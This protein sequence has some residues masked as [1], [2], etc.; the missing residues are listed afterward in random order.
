MLLVLSPELCAQ[1]FFVERA[2][3]EASNGAAGDKH[4]KAVSVS[5]DSALVGARNADGTNADAGAAYVYLRDP[6]G[7]TEQAVL[8]A[9]DEAAGDAFGDAVSIWGDWALVGAP[10]NDDAANDAGSAYVFERTGTLWT[11][12]ALLVPGDLSA[13][14]RFGAS[15]SL[16]GDTAL[17][18]AR[19]GT[20]VGANTG[21]AYVYRRAGT[22]W[23]QEGKLFASDGSFGAE[24]G[25]S[26]SLSGDT[27]LVGAPELNRGVPDV[28]GAYAFRRA[29]TV[30]SQEHKFPGGSVG[31]HFGFSVSLSGDTALIGVPHEHTLA[32]Q[33][34]GAV[35]FY[36]RAGTTWSSSAYIWD[37]D[38]ELGDLFGHSVAVDGD[39]AVVGAPGVDASAND[40]GFVY[41]YWRS[42]TSWGFGGPRYEGS[43]TDAGDGYGT[44]VALSGPHY[45]AG[46]PGDAPAGPLSGS[47]YVREEIP[48]VPPT[49]Y[50]TAGTS[51]SGCQAQ[52]SSLG[53]PSATRNDFFLAT[54][55][56]L[57]GGKAGLFYFGTSGKQAN[58]WGNGT[59]LQCVTPPVQRTGI[60]P[61]SGTPGSCDGSTTLDLNALWCP[62][63]P[64]PNIN[65]GAGALVRLQFWYRDPHN[66]SSRSTS[67]SDALEFSVRD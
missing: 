30:W 28:G 17:V 51:S 48:L 35:A 9:S 11:E 2:K 20:G 46:A 49:N 13:G 10:L 3:F 22:A 44:A 39:R 4:G 32:A 15:V 37:F 12:R 19:H 52:L 23:S 8:R 29:G 1:T 61:G 66:T 43:D 36:E 63:C 45:V 14:D 50:C 60:L 7:W 62:T 65:P 18:G 55:S 6:S 57:E 27:A 64:K 38:G 24:F 53:Q 25:F 54:A 47:A 58:P 5:G 56:G 26:V 42:G 16:E 59:S 67:L 33:D 34:S 40:G 41:V 31:V 21:V